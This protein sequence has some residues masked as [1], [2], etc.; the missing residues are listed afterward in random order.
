MRETTEIRLFNRR[1]L[2]L[3]AAFLLLRMLCVK[4]SLTVAVILWAVA[5]FCAFALF[6]TKMIN[7]GVAVA[8]VAA[9][10]LG[11]GVASLALY[12]R[13]E[14]GFEGKDATV[15]CR[16][17]QVTARVTEDEEGEETTLYRVTADKVKIGDS[18]AG[19]IPSET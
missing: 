19:G 18:Y 14:V 2:P 7:R 17:I 6:F 13:N 8:L 12:V 16:V 1:Y 11:Y 9:L 4:V 5:A 15:T 3:F 10:F